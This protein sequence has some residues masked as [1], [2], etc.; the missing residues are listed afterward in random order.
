[1]SDQAESDQQRTSPTPKQWVQFEESEVQPTQSSPTE[2][3]P[4]NYNGAVI[5][6][7]TVQ[8]DMDKVKQQAQTVKPEVAPTPVSVASSATRNQSHVLR[9]VN[10]DEP[11]NGSLSHTIVLHTD[12]TIQRGFGKL[13]LTCIIK[14]LDLNI[15]N[16]LS[17]PMEM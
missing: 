11:V 12:P 5:E 6:A 9:S 16:I 3:N 10:L 15:M 17:Q 14:Y 8:I 7:E 13:Y 1:M 2:S 4:A